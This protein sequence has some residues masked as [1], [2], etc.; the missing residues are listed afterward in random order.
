MWVILYLGIIA[1]GLCFYLW[2]M[3]ASRVSTGT[4]AAANN[5]LVPLGV[6]LSILFK[7]EYPQWGVFLLGSAVIACALIVAPKENPVNAPL[8]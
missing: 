1:S 3:G 5:L 7:K 4:L 8:E 6:V 2:N